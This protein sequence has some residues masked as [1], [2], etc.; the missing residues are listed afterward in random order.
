MLNKTHEHSSAVG[1]QC[2]VG[3]SA[4]G[5]NP[6]QLRYSLTEST[7]TL[8]ETSQFIPEKKN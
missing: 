7:N 5:V 2:A 1:I 8:T 3:L 6:E 4:L